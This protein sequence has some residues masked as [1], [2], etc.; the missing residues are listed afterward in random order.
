MGESMPHML[1]LVS[2]RLTLTALPFAVA[3]SA[4]AQS[5]S[6]ADAAALASVVQRYAQALRSNDV[7]ALVALYADDGVFMP[8]SAPVAAG[9]AALRTAYRTIF[10][11][12]KLDLEF[13]VLES[14]ASGDMAWVRSQSQGKVKTLAT[15][16]EVQASYNELC[17]FGRSSGTWKLRCFLYATTKPGAS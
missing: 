11:T 8:E 16:V 12:L 13:R 15:G 4:Q 14:Q 9:R 2:R 3:G 7:E 17:V 5:A 10:G 6:A 1:S